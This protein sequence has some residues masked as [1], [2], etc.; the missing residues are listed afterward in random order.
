MLELIAGKYRVIIANDPTH[1]VGS[2]DNVNSYGHECYLDETRAEYSL[3]SR[4]AVRFFVE[5]E[6][7]TTCILMAGGGASG[8]HEDSAIIHDES[9]I[10]AVGPF[11]ASLKIP[12]L[13]L[14]WKCQTDT[15]TCF[16]VYRSEKHRCF[17]SHG[18]LEIARCPTMGKLSGSPAA[19][20]SY[21]WHN[22][23]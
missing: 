5:N 13:D 4:H 1:T 12:T 21:K 8:I 10:I 18:E 19:L 20:T 15:A 2:A 14:E 6:L 9:C 16:G 22:D 3:T 11:L 17:I 7:I 23:T